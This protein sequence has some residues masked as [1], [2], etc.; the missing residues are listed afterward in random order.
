MVSFSALFTK[1]GR[2]GEAFQADPILNVQYMLN[3]EMSPEGG[4]LAHQ[5]FNYYLD[6]EKPYISQHK[7]F[8]KVINYI[9]N[10]DICNTFML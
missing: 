1:Q 7:Q 5:I 3:M 10:R 9:I 4:G 8:E 2:E 6:K